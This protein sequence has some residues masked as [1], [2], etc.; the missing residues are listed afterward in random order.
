[1]GVHLER[2]ASTKD[3]DS[4]SSNQCDMPGTS[5]YLQDKKAPDDQGGADS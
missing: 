2:K 1:M 5:K 3:E 4:M